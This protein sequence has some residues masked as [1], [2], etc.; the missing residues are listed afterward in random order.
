MRDLKQ[1]QARVEAYRKNASIPHTQRELAEAIPLDKDELSK[2]LN[3]HKHPEKQIS[4]LTCAQVQAIV[5]VLARWGAI[6]T[7]EQA[8]ELLDLMECPHFSPSDWQTNPLD[9]L[10]RASSAR[11]AST[12]SMSDSVT[13]KRRK[14]ER[15][16]R[17]RAMQIDHSGFLRNR[18]ESFVGRES[19]LREIHQHIGAMLL[20]GGYITIMGQ[21]G[22]GKSSIIAKLVEEYGPEKTAHHF[23]PFNPGHDYQV[24]LLRDLMAR[25][26]LKYDLSDLYVTS[27]SR[28]ALR[29]Y[30]PKVLA[31]SVEKGGHE[32]IFIDGLDQLKEDADGERDLSFLPNNPPARVVFVLGTRPDDTLYPLELRKPHQRYELP[33]VSRYDFDLILDHRGVKLDTLRIDRCYQLMQK[34]AL[35]LDLLAKELAYEEG[36]QY[37]Q[38]IKRVADDPE[39]LFS[40]S[41]A[42]LKRH[43]LEWRE[44]L[45]PLLGVLLVA[46]EPLTGRHMKNILKI[47]EDRLLG[48][49]VW[50]GGLIVDDGRQRYS[51][52][53]SKLYDYLRQD[54]SNPHKAYVFATDEEENWHT[55]LAN[56]CEQENIS[57][58]WEDVK[59]DSV[60]QGRRE[61]VRRYFVT[62]LYYAK[63]W[64]RLF[65][66]LDAGVYGRAKLGYDQGTR[67]YTLDLMLGRQVAASEE[68]TLEESIALLPRL[69]QYTLLQCRLMSRVERYPEQGFQLLLMLNRVTEALSLAELLI[70]PVQKVSVLLQIAEYLAEQPGRQSEGMQVLMRASEVACRIDARDRSL[71]DLKSRILAEVGRALAR[72]QLWEHTRFVLHVLNEIDEISTIHEESLVLR[73]LATALVRVQQWAEAEAVIH[74]IGENYEKASALCYLGTAL[75][76]AQQWERAQVL[77]AEAAGQIFWISNSWMRA[78]ALGELGA[79]MAQVQQWER[80]Q[81]LWEEAE[82]LIRTTEPDSTRAS[83]LLNLGITLAQAQQ[84]E[85]A[86]PLWVEAEALIRMY[87]EGWSRDELLGKLGGELAKAQQWE[88]ARAV[89]RG[90]T[91]SEEKAKALGELGKAM[92]QVQQW[93]RAYAL[94]AEAE[95]LIRTI[96]WSY[97]RASS[98][99]NL[100]VSLAQAQQWERAQALWTESGALLRMSEE[101]WLKAQVLRTLGTALAKGQQWEHAQVVWAEVEAISR[102]F[103]VNYAKIWALRELGTAL[104]EAQQ[105]EQAQVV[106]KDAAAAA[107][108]LEGI[109]ERVKVV[110]LG[111]LSLALAK[112][113]Q[114]EQAQVVWAE[115][116]KAARE[117]KRDS[118]KSRSTATS[119]KKTGPGTAVGA[120]TCPIGRG[121][122]V[123]EGPVNG[124]HN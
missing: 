78:K 113:Q 19:E 41:I 85:R 31:E 62:H 48:G 87:E 123:A 42:R 89:V 4:P 25:L 52:F 118:A 26:I 47:E 112:A 7:Q 58:I 20:T 82:R 11:P 21:A 116:E 88:W 75:A 9:L 28:S 66:V 120:S 8:R 53:H 64:Q 6:E 29:D 105:W 13:D 79:T 104:A 114:W 93:E 55:V 67:L 117:L 80:A 54:E 37:E 83:S 18:L 15:L 70:K 63:Q 34:N 119:R 115:A 101:G 100:G 99:L 107:L 24:S 57:T 71:Q 23:I 69:W 109:Y 40:L 106:W 46:R 27:E 39:N 33:N 90:I 77:W 108:E 122:A 94:W 30:L 22:Q 32:V 121:A 59:R 5:R 96:T 35:Y 38:I 111:R 98:L 124:T 17:L 110:E 10:R 45:K 72:A 86:Q 44:V 60:E 36:V 3:A 16:A 73:E 49:L 103:E 84:W 61:Y 74:T 65:A 102:L 56:W 92:A 12:Q 76:Q 97:T 2:R 50:L 51:L 14:E 68:W 43:P 95:G 91:K 1:F 81:S